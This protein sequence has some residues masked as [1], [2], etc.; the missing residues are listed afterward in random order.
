MR[1][2]V[3]TG[4][5]HGVFCKD[6]SGR[7]SRF[8]HKQTSAVLRS[9]G[10]VDAFGRVDL[11]TGAV[12]FN[13]D[14]LLRLLSL[15]CRDG[16]LDPERFRAF[17]N[18][19]VRL[20]FY[21]DFLY[22]L[23][24]EST[25]A[26]YLAEAAEGAW[27]DELS[28]C[29]RAVWQAIGTASLS[30]ICLA[31][32]DFIHF[33]TTRELLRLMAR[34]DDTDLLGWARQVHSDSTAGHFAASNSLIDA[35]AEIGAGSYIEDSEIGP[36]VRI[37]LDC[38]LS[39]VCLN[40]GTVP[41]HTVLSGLQL[42]D[43]RYLVRCYD[44][45]DNPKDG[46]WQSARFRAAASRAEAARISLADY[47]AL[48]QPAEPARQTEIADLAQQT[49]P[50]ADPGASAPDPE[51]FSL[52][53]SFAQADVTAALAWQD[54][55][56]GRVTVSRLL[57][58]LR[59]QQPTSACIDSIGPAG[60]T[61]EQGD[62]LLAH[63]DELTLGQRLRL[64][65]ILGRLEPT[66][67]E[68]LSGLGHASIRASLC[69]PE[70]WPEPT[71]MN[72]RIG[73]ATAEVRLPLRVN[74][75]G[76]WS[77]TPPWCLEHG[78]TVLNTAVSVRGVWPV[79]A[80]LERLADRVVRIRISDTGQTATFSELAPLQ[81]CANP[82]D[83]FALAKSAL[84]ACG[85]LPA[86]GDQ[87]LEQ[88]LSRLGGGLSLDLGVPGIPRG[89]GL[90]TSSILG[91]ACIQAIH[92]LLGEPIDAQDVIRLVLIMEQLL[93]TGGG[94]Q[95]QAGALFP[96]IKLLRT[97]PGPAQIVRCTPVCLSESARSALDRRF[98]LI[99]TGQRRLARNL[100][101]D[102]ID[103]TVAGEPAVLAIL[104][105]MQQVAVLMAYEL[106]R[107]RVDGLA[108]LLDRHW[109]LLRQLAPASTN[110]CIEHIFRA[111]ADLLAGRMICGA[112]GGGFL[113]V[114]LRDDCTIQDLE[115]RL[116]AVFGDSGVAVWPCAVV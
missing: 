27:S 5:H 32:A 26:S 105:E 70:L 93:S 44:V 74:W 43:G 35:Q 95:D 41:D 56:T 86:R 51:R 57:R 87:P 54:D 104:H 100:L 97:D 33:G 39:Q 14:L 65:Q 23:A 50:A 92:D 79:S 81:A 20:S 31:P 68:Q 99:Y 88:I 36:H 30:L 45:D 83:P 34:I 62:A 53:S 84:V 46:L 98:A 101:R 38:V 103:R 29:R 77:D 89:S 12:F 10:A 16:R 52:G 48:K 66:R 42:G 1:V 69:Q 37:G 6:A 73:R 2:P 96:G 4:Q 91:A 21:G 24:A 11:D 25:L 111:C 22:P 78:G 58:A 61:P 7:V 85:V 109:D 72:R 107:G 13:T 59:R 67:Q 102:V 116:G 9:S 55:L 17:V 3:E 112:G 106:D 94:W 108:G 115:M 75:G 8:L 18:E 19:R 40:A 113:Q 49:A 114:I 15:I 63:A 71:R 90:G 64:Y 110:T 80:R 28:E 60:L 82:F 47:L 76:A